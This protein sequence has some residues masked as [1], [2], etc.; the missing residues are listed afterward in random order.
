MLRDELI[1]YLFNNQSHL[2]AESMAT[3]LA[4]SRRF[5]AFVTTFR[6]KI[7]KKLHATTEIQS[8]LDLRLELETA[9]LLLQERS[10]N[11][12]YEP[13]PIGQI[14][15][16]D[17]AV[18]CTTSTVFLIEV[19]RLRTVRESTRDL[20]QSQRLALPLA[21]A[22]VRSPTGEWLADMVCSKLGQLL[23]RRG[24]ILLVGVES[25]SLTQD[26]LRGAMRRLQQGVERNDPTILP[27]YRFRD[28]ADFFQQYE[29]LS[30]LLV[31]GPHSQAGEP[32]I[33]WVNPQAKYALPNRVRKVLYRSLSI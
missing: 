4:S 21:A 18:T 32:L 27:R 1:T 5:S 31:R 19:T 17:F 2:L 12:V 23:P 33:S 30:E 24:N 29:R 26:S 10:L 3:W 6:A 20:A 11:L 14:R 25:P 7:R 15:G 28:R 22:P 8:L 16:P 9:Y 13:S